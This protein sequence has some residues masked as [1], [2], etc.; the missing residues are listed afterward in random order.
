MNDVCAVCN[1]GT[2]A[3]KVFDAP[4]IVTKDSFAIL[5]CDHCGV[6]KTHPVPED[7]SR[8]YDNE[9]GGKFM[10][11]DPAF[12]AFLKSFLLKKEIARI[13]KSRRTRAT[14]RPFAC[15]AP[16]MPPRPPRSRAASPAARAAAAP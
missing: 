16:L 9:L 12:F 1:K 8:Y 10:R 4:D 6:K 13:G 5:E 15:A 3:G 14:S 2:I 7:L 11:R